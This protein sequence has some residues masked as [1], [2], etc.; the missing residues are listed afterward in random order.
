MRL[1]RELTGWL[2]AEWAGLVVYFLMRLAWKRVLG[3]L[4]GL[5]AVS[6]GDV[7]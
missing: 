5:P 6:S 3:A 4:I 7:H 2:V 1:Q